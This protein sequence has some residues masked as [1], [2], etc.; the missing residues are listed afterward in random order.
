M[1]NY[2]H[3]EFKCELCNFICKSDAQL[4]NHK[5]TRNCIYRQKNNKCIEEG[6]E[7]IPENKQPVICK[8][9]PG[10]ICKNFYQY[11]KH[12]ETAVHKQNVKK[13]IKKPQFCTVCGK[14]NINSDLK[15]RRHLKTAKKCRKIATLSDEN[16]KKWTTLYTVFHCRFP[17]ISLEKDTIKIKVV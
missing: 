15:M 8:V 17:K 11:K 13:N 2:K 9:C 14:K 16:I 10:K 4:L 12:C 1:E 7:Y 6:T 5:H 3:E